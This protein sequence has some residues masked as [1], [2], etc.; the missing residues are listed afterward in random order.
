MCLAVQNAFLCL[1]TFEVPTATA[2]HITT[3][4]SEDGGSPFLKTLGTRILAVI[5]HNCS[6]YIQHNMPELYVPNYTYITKVI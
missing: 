2:M 1:V 4:H 5:T 6:N 3:F